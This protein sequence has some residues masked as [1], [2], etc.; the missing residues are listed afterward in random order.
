LDIPFF[1]RDRD[2]TINYELLV[3]LLDF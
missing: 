2:G 3:K 1:S